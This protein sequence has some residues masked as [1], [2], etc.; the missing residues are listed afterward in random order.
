[1]LEAGKH[2]LVEKPVATG[3][4]A[5]ERLMEARPAPERSDGVLCA[6]AMCM[7][8]WPEWAWLKNTI[9]SGELGAVRSASFTRLGAAPAWSGFYATRRGRAGRSSICTCTTW[10]SCCTASARRRR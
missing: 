7:R 5:I 3:T 2:V 4:A 6:P 9:E 10:T 1:M 8:F